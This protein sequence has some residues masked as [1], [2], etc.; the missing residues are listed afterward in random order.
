MTISPTVEAR[1]AIIAALKLAPTVTSLVPASRLYTVPPANP[2]KPFGRYGI[3]GSE[4]FRAAGWRG[5]DVDGSFDVVVSKA[6]AI[7]DPRAYAAQA[8]AAIA[9]IL[10]AMPDCNVDRTV[11]VESSEADT[12]RA[13]VYFTISIVEQL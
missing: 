5:G 9:E 6:T 7:S 11:M 3:D 10:D 1:S 13:V 12:W 4:P 8:I 2:V